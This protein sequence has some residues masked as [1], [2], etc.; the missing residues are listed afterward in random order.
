MRGGNAPSCALPLLVPSALVNLFDLSW[1]DHSSKADD[2]PGFAHRS[3]NTH[4]SIFTRVYFLRMRIG[5][6]IFFIYLSD[7][8]LLNFIKPTFLN[9]HSLKEI[10][11][12]CDETKKRC[13]ND[14]KKK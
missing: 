4:R 14:F 1:P 13:G 8:Y 5:R 10:E 6:K 9:L 3:I 11:D 2:G 7:I 12:V